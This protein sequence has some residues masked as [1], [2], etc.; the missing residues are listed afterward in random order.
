MCSILLWLIASPATTSATSAHRAGRRRTRRRGEATVTVVTR[1]SR[2]CP[3]V[4]FPLS[5][6]ADIPSGRSVIAGLILLE[7][8]TILLLAV[9][10]SYRFYI[11]VSIGSAG[12]SRLDILQ[13]IIGFVRLQSEL[14]FLR[15]RILNSIVASCPKFGTGR[16]TFDTIRSAIR[17]VSSGMLTIGI[18]LLG[19]V[20]VVMY[21]SRIA[22][23]TVLA[24]PAIRISPTHTDSIGIVERII[25]VAPIPIISGVITAP[26]DMATV[27]EPWIVPRIV[28]PAGERWIP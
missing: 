16:S 10:W 4:I 1:R 21:H 2:K 14:I 7:Y 19:V 18:G 17:I 28:I 27:V 3:I 22:T 6:A 15:G 9:V 25:V 26:S 12:T 20:V 11:S 8:G 23:P 13:I 5:I 24:A